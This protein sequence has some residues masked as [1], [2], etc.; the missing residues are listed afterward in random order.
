MREIKER[1]LN[2]QHDVLPLKDEQRPEKPREPSMNEVAARISDQLLVTE[3]DQRTR[4]RQLVWELGR[5]QAQALCAEVFVDTEI[6]SGQV[7]VERFFRLIE[8]KGVKKERPWL[9]QR[10][11]Q[12]PSPRKQLDVTPAQEGRDVA[13]LIATQLEER[14]ATAWATIHRSVIALGADAAL[15]LLQKTHD[16]EAAG[17]MLVPDGSRRRT[18]GGVYFWLVRQ[19]ATEAQHR[20][21]F[22]YGGPKSPNSGNPTH[23]P[24]KPEAKKATRPHQPTSASAFV[25]AERGAFLVEVA[26]NKGDVK[27]VKITL[28]GRP[29]QIVEQGRCF[30]ISMQ[31]AA[32]I[33]PLPAGLPL[34]PAEA[35]GATNYTV[36]IASKQ[37]R[38]VAEAITDEEDSLI[39]EGLPFLDTEHQA[40]AVLASN[41]T[42]RNLQRAAK[43][44]KSRSGPEASNSKTQADRVQ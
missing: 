30:L 41:V 33:P 14:K 28:V 11:D 34:P 32:K 12:K 15:A 26:Q 25:W 21:I 40:I 5:T 38:K 31:Q 35:I 3:E 9:R 29:G 16:V 7:L 42:T 44:P 19:E 10:N 17:G 43:A 27:T 13:K 18:P 2:D 37:W 1:F 22:Q 24:K 36:Y 8:T 20:E 39:I 6:Q 23:T 4:I